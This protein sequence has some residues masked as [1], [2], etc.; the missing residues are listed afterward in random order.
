MRPNGKQTR[1]QF[2]EAR[3][4]A[5]RKYRAKN[6]E[7]VREMYREYYYRQTEKCVQRAELWCLANPYAALVAGVVSR[8]QRKGIP[9]DQ[10]YLRGLVSPER[11]PVFGTPIGFNLTKGQRPH[12]NTAS[13]DQIIPGQGYV[14]GNVQIMSKLAN[15]MKNNATPEQLLQFSEWIQK[16][17]GN[18]RL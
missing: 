18:R 17:Y 13:I 5:Q 2:L 16:T 6:P 4:V 10:K 12:I 7:R 14:P 11:C 8:A 15:Q 3:R 9:Y 1:A